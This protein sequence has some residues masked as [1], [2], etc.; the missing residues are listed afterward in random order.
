[1]FSA[2]IPVLMS[3]NSRDMKCIFRLGENHY[4]VENKTKQKNSVS[5]SPQANYTD[6][7]TATCWRNLVT[8]FAD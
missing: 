2:P 4:L 3:P 5:F 7:A 8:T 1:M 6:L